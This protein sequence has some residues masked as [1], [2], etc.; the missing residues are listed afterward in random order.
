M[1]GHLFRYVLWYN[2]SEWQ[3]T[4]I[5]H[6][7]GLVPFFSITYMD[8]HVKNTLRAENVLEKVQEKQK[9]DPGP[10]RTQHQKCWME[11]EEKMGVARH[12]FL[13]G[14]T[15]SSPADSDAPQE[16]GYTMIAT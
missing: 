2:E 10:C 6:E 11:N 14:K 4:Q 15:R 5:H 3:L 1:E 12:S 9:G 16:E 13:T 8:Q 7:L